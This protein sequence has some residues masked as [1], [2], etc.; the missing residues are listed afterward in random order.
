[1][2][3][4]GSHL[5]VHGGAVPHPR[6]RT[7][8][9]DLAEGGIG[10]ARGSG[11]DRLVDRD[12]ADSRVVAMEAGQFRGEDLLPSCQRYPLRLLDGPTART[13]TRTG[14]R[15]RLGSH[16]LPQSGTPWTRTDSCAGRGYVPVLGAWFRTDRGGPLVVR[17]LPRSLAATA[18][19]GAAYV[20]LEYPKRA[21]WP[22]PFPAQRS[23]VRTLTRERA[24]EIYH[25]QLDVP[26]ASCF[27]LM[28]PGRSPLQALPLA[29]LVVLGPALLFLLA[30]ALHA[31]RARRA[32]LLASNW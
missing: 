11:R 26:P 19:E 24:T 9:R 16:D 14:Q 3:I 7:Y 18:L 2:G 20:E 22:P 29:L 17:C 30:D 8:C 25:F 27:D 23:V 4:S 6:I 12:S 5:C 31:V 1:M 10:C 32:A 21:I 13:H 15:G 28:D